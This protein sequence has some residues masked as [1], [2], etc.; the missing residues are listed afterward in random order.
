MIICKREGFKYRVQES[1]ISKQIEILKESDF[2]KTDNGLIVIIYFGF[3][4]ELVRSIGNEILENVCTSDSDKRY[5]VDMREKEKIA[6]ASLPSALKE[7]ADNMEEDGISL[8]SSAKTAL[9]R[10]VTFHSL[11]TAD[12]DPYIKTG[13]IWTKTKAE[14]V[15]SLMSYDEQRVV[16]CI[17]L[18]PEECFRRED[19][20]KFLCH[21][22]AE[23]GSA[24]LD[25]NN[26]CHPKFIEFILFDDKL[27][28]TSDRRIIKAE[29]V[30]FCIPKSELAKFISKITDY[31][32]VD[33]SELH[34]DDRRL[35]LLLDITD[36]I[37][38]D[39]SELS[40][41]ERLNLL[42]DNNKWLEYTLNL[43]KFISMSY[44]LYEHNS[45]SGIRKRRNKSEGGSVHESEVGGT[46]KEEEVRQ[47]GIEEKIK[48]SLNLIPKEV[49]YISAKRKDL[50]KDK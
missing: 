17:V 32:R 2:A 15:S 50:E 41:D 34:K 8:D 21:D 31:I 6:N 4:T 23:R 27:M 47:N 36:C 16:R 22:D 38:V 1:D 14:A 43:P 19:I 13:N 26:Y 33:H 40:I 25:P 3:N 5:V 48:I 30:Y 12:N 46:H 35:T 9:D 24:D 7:L 18:L 44:D 45:L 37:R 42:L 20:I 28:S 39:Y 49:E 11:A 29:D 10:L